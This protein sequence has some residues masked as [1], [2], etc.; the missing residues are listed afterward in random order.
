MTA[1][2]DH[3]WQSTVFAAL[4]FLLSLVLRGNSARV[5][6]FLWIAASLKFLI[7][8]SLLISAG[9]SLAPAEAPSVGP[10]IS[11]VA[12]QATEPFAT[13][14]FEPS[15]V[16]PGGVPLA[17]IAAVVWVFGTIFTL[18]VWMKHWRELRGAVREAHVA[19]DIRAPIPVLS[20]PRLI[21]PG[22]VGLFRPVLLLPAGLSGKLSPQQVE[23]LI[24]HEMSHVRRHDNLVAL[25]HMLVEAIFWFHPLVWWIGARLMEE[26]ERACDEDVLAKGKAPEAY[27]QGI[28]EVCKFYLRSPLPCASGI[29]GSDLKARVSRIMAGRV[30]AKLTSTRKGALCAAG[31]VAV[32]APLFVGAIRADGLKYDIASIRPNDSA[33]PN[34]RMGPRPDGGL[35]AQNVTALQL[36]TFAYDMQD[37]QVSGGPEWLKSARF[38]VIAKMDEPIKADPLQMSAPERLSFISQHRQRMQSLLAERLGLSVRKES[39]ELPGYLLT[40]AKSGSKLRPSTL[41]EQKQNMRMGRGRL[42]AGGAPLTEVAKAFSQVLRRKVVDRTALTGVYDLTLEWTPDEVAADAA[43]LPAGASFSTAVQEQL[44]LRLESGRVPTDVIVVEQINKPS[45][46]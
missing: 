29:T 6:Y 37:F 33:S 36:I 28:V 4:V 27:A 44:G 15:V 38:D 40:T 2:L 3:L 1:V 11:K 26:R 18:A 22:V 19:D 42:E 39:K 17:P 41:E 5:R 12:V 25:V 31:V 20:C 7:P 8:F 30:G 23:S 34:S 16:T 24:E 14:S 43:D 21:E 46:N 35:Q 10:A 9:D 45:E 32:A 13:V